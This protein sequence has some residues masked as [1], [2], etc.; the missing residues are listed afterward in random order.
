MSLRIEIHW[1][2]HCNDN[3][4]HFRLVVIGPAVHN[5]WTGLVDWTSGLDWWTTY[6]SPNFFSS[7]ELDCFSK[8]Y[9]LDLPDAMVAWSE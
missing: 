8:T 1:A 6:F 4:V 7:E 2:S 9:S 3:T 5:H